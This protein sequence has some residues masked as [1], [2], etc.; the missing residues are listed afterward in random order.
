MSR[1]QKLVHLAARITPDGEADWQRGVFSA[2]Q[3]AFV[4]TLEQEAAGW[5]CP[6]RRAVFGD[7]TADYFRQSAARSAVSIANT[8][9]YHL[10]LE[11]VRIGQETPT[12]NRHVYARRLFYD[13]G[14]WARRYWAEKSLEIAVTETGG[15]IAAAK[16]GF[17][18]RNDWLGDVVAQVEVR[19]Y[20]T[21]CEV[22]RAVVAGNPYPSRQALADGPGAP[23]YHIKCPHYEAV[24][25]SR[26]LTREEC[27]RLWMG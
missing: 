19:P 23:P 15:A 20:D 11:I 17:Y 21:V 1:V 3:R 27:E 12:A 25:G 22:C 2:H 13:Q 5:G 9:N 4:S 14:S 8:Y 7:E 26:Q 18:K 24:T 6:G 10:A 16:D